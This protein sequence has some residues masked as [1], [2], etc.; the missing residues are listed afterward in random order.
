[1]AAIGVVIAEDTSVPD[2]TIYGHVYDAQSKQPVSQAFVYCQAAKCKPIATDSDG[3]YAIDNC[4]SPSSDYVVECTKNG[5]PTAKNTTK[6]DSRGKAKV[7]FNLGNTPNL[8]PNP[9]P[10]KSWKKTFG[11]SRPANG[12]SVQQ[13]SDGGYIIA[14][15]TGSDVWLIKTDD[16]GNKIWDRVFGGSN[17]NSG[18]S[19]QQTS[20]GGYIIAGYTYQH[21]SSDLLDA[22]NSKVLLIKTDANGN[23]LWDRT[24][25]RSLDVNSN[26]GQQTMQSSEPLLRTMSFCPPQPSPALVQQTRDNGYIVVGQ[27][28]IVGRTQDPCGRIYDICLLKT[29]ANGNKQWDRIFSESNLDGGKSIQQTSDGGYIIAGSAGDNDAGLIRVDA[30]GRKELDRALGYEEGWASLV[31]QTI[32]NGYIVEGFEFNNTLKSFYAWQV[33]TDSKGN[34]QSKRVLKDAIEIYGS[35]DL[36]Q[37]TIDGGHIIVVGTFST[38]NKKGNGKTIT[39]DC[40]AFDDCIMKIDSQG[41]EEWRRI[42][43]GLGIDEANSVQETRDSGYIIVGSTYDNC[44]PNRS[45]IWLIKTDSEGNVEG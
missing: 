26:L 42:L 43:T 45:K 27:T 28:K 9:T 20:D 11:G 44:D 25:N 14:G 13:T 24:F 31:Q 22:T 6:T 12:Y 8:Q 10:S 37:Q 4:F 7:D 2:G 5:Y 35:L 29:D 17:H 39:F 40:S 1:M 18:Q 19:V 15:E 23:K 33:K 41:N 16:D 36:I 30:E 3:Y 38:S 34:K 32:D 21:A